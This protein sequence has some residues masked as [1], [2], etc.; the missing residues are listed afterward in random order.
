MEQKLCL[1]IGAAE[2]DERG[3]FERERCELGKIRD[4][5]LNTVFIFQSVLNMGC[6]D[7]KIS[8]NFCRQDTISSSWY[9]G[10][11]GNLVRK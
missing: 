5:N 11:D 6:G 7:T 8:G 2:T 3:I 4:Q 1:R 10:S 9:R